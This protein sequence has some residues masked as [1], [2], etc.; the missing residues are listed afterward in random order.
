[1]GGK[2][3]AVSVGVLVGNGVSV[4]GASVIVGVSV[5]GISVET[6]VSVGFG[7]VVSVSFGGK[8]V[9]M[10]SVA[11]GVWQPERTITTRR[12]TTKRLTPNRSVPQLLSERP[13]RLFREVIIVSFPSVIDCVI[14]D[15]NAH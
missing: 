12:D 4:G 11:W 2:G 8:V 13:R 6:G 14:S 1:M 3:V 5:G 7:L 15:N 10:I 9:G